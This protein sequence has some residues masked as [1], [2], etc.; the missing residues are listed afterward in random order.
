MVKSKSNEYPEKWKI[1][2]TPSLQIHLKKN[3]PLMTWLIEIAE[4][5]IIEHRL[6]KKK[7]KSHEEFIIFTI[8]WMRVFKTIFTK[9]KKDSIRSDYNRKN[10]LVDNYIKN[11]YLNQQDQYLGMTINAI[12][13]ESEIPRSTVKRII[14]NLIKKKLVTKNL[15]NLIIPTYKVR[16]AMRYY[17]QYIYKS[18]KRTY[19]IFETLN[20][21]NLYDENNII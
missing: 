18:H 4:E 21:M 6:L 17:R 13:R 12:T 11:Y 19:S 2:N 15:K 5:K 1:K 20:M 9:L 7:F 16:D 10:I 8:I 3:I 14:E